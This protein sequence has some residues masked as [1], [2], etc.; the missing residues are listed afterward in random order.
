MLSAAVHCRKQALILDFERQIKI[1]ISAALIKGYSGSIKRELPATLFSW[2]VFTEG[3]EMEKKAT[4]LTLVFYIKKSNSFGLY[5]SLE[6]QAVPLEF[7]LFLYL[8]HICIRTEAN[9]CL[10]L[11][12]L[13]LIE[14]NQVMCKCAVLRQR[15]ERCVVCLSN[16]GCVC[17]N[18]MKG[19]VDN[20]QQQLIP[21]APPTTGTLPGTYVVLAVR[22]GASQE[23]N[24]WA[25]S[26]TVL[27]RKV[28]S[29]VSCLE[30]RGGESQSLIT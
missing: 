5:L 29:S 3:K 20:K 1:M 2:P 4:H 13:C 11:D 16:A 8:H 27:T 30:T 10:N 12:L 21:A 14:N 25:M 19:A 17:I 22:S 15:G 28:E 7:W 26:V 9:K 18:L 24:L 23:Q 6:S